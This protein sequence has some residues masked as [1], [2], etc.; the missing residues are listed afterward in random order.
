[1]VWQRASAH[2]LCL[3]ERSRRLATCRWAVI[4]TIA[5]ITTTTA[6]E[7]RSR[8]GDAPVLPTHIFINLETS[9]RPHIRCKHRVEWAI[10]SRRH[11]VKDVHQHV[12]VT[13]TCKLSKC[14]PA[15]HRQGH[16]SHRP[17]NNQHDADTAVPPYAQQRTLDAMHVV[18]ACSAIGP[19]MAP[20]PKPSRTLC[21]KTLWYTSHLLT[22]THSRSLNSR[23]S[24]RR[25]Q[26]TKG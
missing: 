21:C 6:Q 13:R 17:S 19:Q 14:R 24:P 5:P 25:L 18:I 12:Y 1:V 8:G 26:G 16:H 11:A 22:H 4:T 23:S 3:N 7:G 20:F 2:L 9:R 15:L 10:S